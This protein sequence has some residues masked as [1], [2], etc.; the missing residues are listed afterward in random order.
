MRPTS[1]FSS[2]ERCRLLLRKGK[3]EKSRGF[4]AALSLFAR[5]NT[6]SIP[7][8]NRYCAVVPGCKRAEWL[9]CMACCGCW[10]LC[11]FLH[12]PV[13]MQ[14]CSLLPPPVNPPFSLSLSRSICRCAAVFV[15]FCFE[16]VLV[17]LGIYAPAPAAAILARPTGRFPHEITKFPSLPLNGA[18]S[19]STAGLPV[20]LH[21]RRVWDFQFSVCCLPITVCIWEINFLPF[22]AVSHDAEQHPGPRFGRRVTLRITLDY[23]AQAAALDAENPA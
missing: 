8:S 6:L 12:F 9:H 10:L 18:W 15:A 3:R 5:K 19:A 11:D 14:T 2:L 20:L 23:Y 13:V 16:W 4:G 17:A 1:D 7:L 21:R 22:S